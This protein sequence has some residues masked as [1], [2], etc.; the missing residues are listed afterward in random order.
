MQ[1]AVPLCQ[2]TIRQCKEEPGAARLPARNERKQP[3]R[4][5]AVPGAEKEGSGGLSSAFHF[6]VE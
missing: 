5:A 6:R 3:G 2:A 4:R 1:I